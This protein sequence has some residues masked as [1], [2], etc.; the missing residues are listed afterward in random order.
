MKRFLFSI[1]LIFSLLS[2]AG[3]SPQ[4]LSHEDENEPHESTNQQTDGYYD[5]ILDYNEE[6]TG[7]H[8]K[9]GRLNIS[10]DDDYIYFQIKVSISP[11]LQEK[12]INTEKAF[13]FNITDIEG[14]DNLSSITTEA[15]VFTL[16]DLDAMRDGEYH[17]ITQSI[18][19]K[20][21]VSSEEL[22]EVLLPENYELQFVNANK[23]IVAVIIGLELN[24]IY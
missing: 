10:K 3:C 2:I 4:T 15:P 16:G 18:K 1:L 21:D 11:T 22:K 23:Q 9:T 7:E 17:L 20:K 19:I 5:S 24:T 12:M 13:Y 8:F 14:R 6:I